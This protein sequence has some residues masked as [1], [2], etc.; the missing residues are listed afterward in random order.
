MD[1]VNAQAAALQAQLGKLWN[2]TGRQADA[3]TA[4]SECDPSAQTCSQNPG[5]VG[6]TIRTK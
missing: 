3:A 4:A 6:E 2:A 5:T 1:K